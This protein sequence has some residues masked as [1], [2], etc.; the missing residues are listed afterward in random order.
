MKVVKGFLK[1]LLHCINLMVI[2]VIAIAYAVLYQTNIHNNEMIFSIA[3]W[4][5]NVSIDF[6]MTQITSSFIVVFITAMLTTKGKTIYWEDT[7]HYMLINPP[8]MNL[9]SI[10]DTAFLM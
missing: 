2:I 3:N 8:M 7:I 4:L 9:K 5:D 10:T 6:F 1:L